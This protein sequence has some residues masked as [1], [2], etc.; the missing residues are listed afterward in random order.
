MSRTSL[1]QTG[2]DVFSV[3]VSVA[4]N[5]WMAGHLHGE[6]GCDGSRGPGGHDWQARMR[7]ITEMTAGPQR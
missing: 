7:T 5:A 6:D 4:V 1:A 3:I 2:G